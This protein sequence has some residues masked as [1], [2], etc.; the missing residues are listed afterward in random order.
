MGSNECWLFL[1]QQLTSLHPCFRNPYDYP[2]RTEH[3]SNRNIARQLEAFVSGP[4]DPRTL[5][6]NR[7]PQSLRYHIGNDLLHCIYLYSLY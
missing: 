4:D 5:Q 2:S 1:T 7:E 3:G 6:Y